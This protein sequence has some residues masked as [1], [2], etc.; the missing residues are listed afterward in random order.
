L[1]GHGV[2]LAPPL[3]SLNEAKGMSDDFEDGGP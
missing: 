3:C 1:F 2:H